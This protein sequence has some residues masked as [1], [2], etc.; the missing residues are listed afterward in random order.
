[1]LLVVIVLVQKHLIYGLMSLLLEHSFA[2]RN[3]DIPGRSEYDKLAPR[4]KVCFLG[5][6]D[7][8]DEPPVARKVYYF[9]NPQ[10][11]SLATC[12]CVWTASAIKVFEK[13]HFMVN[14]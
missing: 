6:A 10:S 7:C 9:L 3:N 12:V 5:M 13:V 8:E 11:T 1:M 4:F 14:V 2:N